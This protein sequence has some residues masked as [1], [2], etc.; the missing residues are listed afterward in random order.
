MSVCFVDNF[1]QYGLFIIYIVLFFYYN[2]SS[3][4]LQYQVR[5][6]DKFL[7][8]LGLSTN[9]EMWHTSSK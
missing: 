8:R 4:F 2:G 9:I 3:A 5:N 1:F 7:P 6:T